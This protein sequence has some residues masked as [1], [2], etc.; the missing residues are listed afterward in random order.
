MNYSEIVINGIIE[1]K[2][3]QNDY[4]VFIKYMIGNYEKANKEYQTL[5]SFFKGC[6]NVYEVMIRDIENQFFENR[7]DLEGMIEE[8]EKDLK[9]KKY[10]D[11]FHKEAKEIELN[12]ATKQLESLNYDGF[13]FSLSH[14]TANKHRGYLKRDAIVY[15]KKITIELYEILKKQTENPPSPEPQQ[16]T[17]G[18]NKQGKQKAEQK[19]AID[20]VELE[21]PEQKEKFLTALKEEYIKTDIKG[22][23]KL[24]FAMVHLGI[25]DINKTPRN[26]IKPAFEQLFNKEYGR[27][28]GF[29]KHFR[30]F[31]TRK[32]N[33]C[34]VFNDEFSTIIKE[35][36]QLKQVV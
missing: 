9:N 35:I 31:N 4:N 16:S 13:S 3:A 36:N 6:L 20:C 26:V 21:I 23:A 19:P 25:I 27:Q 28:N 7:R 2:N 18:N 30:D 8:I 14:Y 5:D 10:P 33:D 29:N 24:L 15:L 12:F 11:E 34:R 32:E 22:F 17:K 1:T